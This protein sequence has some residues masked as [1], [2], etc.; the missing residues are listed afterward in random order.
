M[1][2]DAEMAAAAVALPKSLVPRAYQIEMFEESMKRNTIVVVREM[3]S[4]A[5]DG[6]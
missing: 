2:G 1:E 3:A 5:I 4:K 6:C